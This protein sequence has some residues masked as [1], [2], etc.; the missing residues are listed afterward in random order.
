MNNKSFKSILLG[1]TIFCVC[2]ASISA[3]ATTV[4]LNSKG[5]T[6][7]LGVVSAIQTDIQQGKQ[8]QSY[9]YNL[10]S[11]ATTDAII[12]QGLLDDINNG[13]APFYPIEGPVKL[14][15]TGNPSHKQ[16]IQGTTA[17]KGTA[18]SKGKLTLN[19][20]G[21]FTANADDYKNITEESIAGHLENITNYL[22]TNN[23][24]V[25]SND[26]AAVHLIDADLE[27]NNSVFAFSDTS[28]ATNISESG[29]AIFMQKEKGLFSLYY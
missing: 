6:S 25:K 4:D 13:V 18:D 5:V 20:V 14:T 17:I 26:G 12:D 29:A 7:M 8:G 3:G 11:S 16:V 24:T 15:V 27:V 21:S 28:T 1:T 23:A 19:N 10:P 2:F 22:K 9:T